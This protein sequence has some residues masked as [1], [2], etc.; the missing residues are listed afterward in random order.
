M[1]D[2]SSEEISTEEARELIN[3][4]AKEL[5]T[6]LNKLYSGVSYRHCYVMSNGFIAGDLT[7]PHDI[8][9]QPIKEHLPKS[10]AGKK[11]LELQ[12][13]SYVLLKNHPINVERAKNGKRQASS[14]WFYRFS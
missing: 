14:L 9:N 11:L 7:P 8:L 2:Y 6:D 13:K 3:Y 5:N 12:K 10:E 1:A 4:L